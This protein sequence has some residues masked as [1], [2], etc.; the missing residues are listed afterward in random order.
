[1][2]QNS[3]NS[4]WRTLSTRQSNVTVAPPPKHP[5]HGARPQR[6]P[7]PLQY[8][9]FLAWAVTVSSQV[10]DHFTLEIGQKQG[11]QLPILPIGNGY[12]PDE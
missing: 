9:H 2:A 7:V 6:Q 8:D 12:F 3:L 5:N 4:G 1:M 11:H 10:P